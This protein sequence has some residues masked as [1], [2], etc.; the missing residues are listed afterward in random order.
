[1]FQIDRRWNG[2]ADPAYTFAVP[3][4]QYE[5]TLRFAETDQ[6]VI[7][8][9]VFN[10]AIEGVTVLN[11]F[12]IFAAAGGWKLAIDRTFPVTISDGTLTISVTSITAKPKINAIHI[13]RVN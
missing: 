5:V 1:L 13:R 9:R 2:S 7:G 10:V 3:N 8:G 12:D 11:A 6:S 4:G